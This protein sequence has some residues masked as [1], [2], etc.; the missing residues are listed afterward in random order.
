MYI[1]FF[2]VKLLFSCSP[3]PVTW[4]GRCLHGG[5]PH[6]CIALCKHAF[7]VHVKWG[8]SVRIPHEYACHV[9]VISLNIHQTG[10]NRRCVCFLTKIPCKI[11]LNGG[12]KTLHLVKNCPAVSDFPPD[13]VSPTQQCI[14]YERR[15]W[16]TVSAVSCCV[17]GRVRCSKQAWT[18]NIVISRNKIIKPSF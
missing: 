10:S 6:P 12:L 3:S 8:C 2:T 17:C 15:S 18:T 13:M 7:K 9:L 1:I 16:N 11:P 4:F 14:T 5:S